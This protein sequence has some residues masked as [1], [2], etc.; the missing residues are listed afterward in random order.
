[1]KFVKPRNEHATTHSPHSK[2]ITAY[3]NV[4]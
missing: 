2:Q 1:M 4:A 3:N